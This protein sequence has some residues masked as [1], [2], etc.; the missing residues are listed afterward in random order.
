M[1][2]GGKRPSSCE[3]DALEGDSRSPNSKKTKSEDP[4]SRFW[5]LVPVGEMDEGPVVPFL[6]N[7]QEIG[8][9]SGFGDTESLRQLLSYEEVCRANDIL[10]WYSLLDDG[11]LPEEDAFENVFSKTM[12][13][14]GVDRT[15][16][17]LSPNCCTASVVR[18]VGILKHYAEE[19]DESDA[20]SVYED[21]ERRLTIFLLDRLDTAAILSDVQY[22][23]EMSPNVTR[24]IRPLFD[25]MSL[26]ERLRWAVYISVLADQLLHDEYAYSLVC[27]NDLQSWG[28]PELQQQFI[29]LLQSYVDVCRKEWRELQEGV[30]VPQVRA[31]YARMDIPGLPNWMP[32]AANSCYMSSTIWPLAVMLRDEIYEK[33]GN[34]SAVPLRNER[35]RDAFIELFENVTSPAI[36]D[37]TSDAVSSLRKELQQ[38]FPTRF[39]AARNHV[40]EDAYDF[41]NCVLIDLLQFNSLRDRSPRFVTMH[42]FNRVDGAALVEPE[43]YNYEKRLA[44]RCVREPS[45]ILDIRLDGNEHPPTTLG[46]LVT[47]CRAAG[48]V[49]R[50]AKRTTSDHH[51]PAKRSV[52]TRHTEQVV[53]AS[54]AEAPAYL[55]ARLT[56][57]SEDAVSQVRTK[58]R[59]QVFPS[60]T[61]DFRIQS[62]EESNATVQYDLVAVTVHQGER[63]DNGHYYAYLRKEVEGKMRVFK[64]DDI[65][66]P[67][68]LPEAGAAWADAGRN[69]YIYY[70]R[71]R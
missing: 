38:D 12:S 61:L 17:I 32:N 63:L 8:L 56:R 26:G 22:A 28:L 16:Q 34:F 65:G 46:D 52:K 13:F 23:F 20:P 7:L 43:H 60:M 18:L 40:Q 70:Y 54:R 51:G 66:G 15:V 68:L 24:S 44:T 57:F 31:R 67:Q 55:I 59:D 1:D 36:T 58:R 11:V 39:I 5:T 25:E 14:L 71:R 62:E 53:V 45:M 3:V 41:L 27:R 21:F 19:G 9:L 50:V 48:E 64:Y 10:C 69:G 42:K 37:I 4:Y 2:A 49:E 35:A 6:N 29:M 33:I 47:E 30:R